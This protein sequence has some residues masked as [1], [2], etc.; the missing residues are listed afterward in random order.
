MI[1]CGLGYLANY[2]PFNI[3]LILELL[4]SGILVS[5]NQPVAGSMN[6]FVFKTM[7]LPVLSV[8]V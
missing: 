8:I 1:F 2:V 4:L 5:A 6:T 7:P 3:R